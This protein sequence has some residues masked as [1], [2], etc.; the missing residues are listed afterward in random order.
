M[1]VATTANDSNFDSKEGNES[2]G[3]ELGKVIVD[4]HEIDAGRVIMRDQ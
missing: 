2:Y 3:E 4:G 1:M